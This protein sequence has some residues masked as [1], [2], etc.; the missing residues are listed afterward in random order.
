MDFPNLEDT[1]TLVYNCWF[2]I[3]NPTKMD[4]LGISYFRK[5]PYFIVW[6]VTSLGR[7]NVEKACFMTLT[8]ICGFP[9]MGVPP[10]HPFIDGFS[11][12]KHPFWGT[13]LYGHS[14]MLIYFILGGV[15]NL[16]SWRYRDLFLE[17]WYP[18][19]YTWSVICGSPGLE[20]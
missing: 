3:E 10:N 9:K 11:R 15:T 4:D 8:T 13:P 5:P 20:L 18:L 16:G 12:K 6:G 14:H 19:L 7:G 2:I 1:P 17:I